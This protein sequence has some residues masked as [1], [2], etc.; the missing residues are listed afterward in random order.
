MS[1]SHELGRTTNGKES[2]S[3]IPGYRGMLDEVACEVKDVLQVVPAANSGQGVVDE[4]VDFL[5]A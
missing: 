4:A 2:P 5:S 1:R 3:P